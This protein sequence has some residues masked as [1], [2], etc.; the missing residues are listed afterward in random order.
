MLVSARGV[1]G[2]DDL[3]RREGGHI[4]GIRHH[5]NHKQTGIGAGAAIELHHQF[6]NV[7]F[8]V[9]LGQNQAGHL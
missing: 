9:N 4:G 6:G 5:T 3:D 7:E 1:R 8:L 2:R